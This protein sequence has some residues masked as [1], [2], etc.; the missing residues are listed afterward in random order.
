MSLLDCSWHGHPCQK[1]RESK[2]PRTGFTLDGLL[3]R[4]EKREQL[5]RSA[6]YDIVTKWECDFDKEVK[7]NDELKTFLTDLGDI[8]ERLKIKDS[9]H[10]GRTGAVTLYINVEDQP[11]G[12]KIY[13]YD[14]TR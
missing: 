14:F 8:P 13:Y 5:L 9:L 4:T 7:V 10:G 11:P 3:E 2:D 6:G 1:D 12:T